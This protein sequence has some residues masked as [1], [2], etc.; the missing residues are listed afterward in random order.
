MLRRTIVTAAAGAVGTMAAAADTARAAPASPGVHKL[1][2][3]SAWPAEAAG[4]AHAVLRFAQ[5][6]RALS[7]GGI[8]IEVL[9]ADRSGVPA[10]GLMDAVAQGEVDL[11]HS[12]AYYWTQRSPGFSFFATVPMGMMANEHYGWLR[13][14]GGLA[15][16]QKLAAEHG[17]M[18]L[19]CGNTG[20]QMGGWFR[21]PLQ[22]VASLK[23]LKLRFPGLGGEVLRR[24]G[25]EPV[26]LPAKDLK[27]ALADGRLDGA[28]W[29]TPWPDVALGLHELCRY[30]YYPGV[31][32]PSHTLE[33]LINP[34]VWQRLGEAQREVLQAAAWLEC[35][36]M[37]AHFHHENA[38]HLD[39]LQ[40]LRQV[41][42]L[43]LPNELMR[44]FRKLAP[45]VVRDAVAKDAFARRIHDSYTAYLA[46]QLR[47]AEMADRAYWQARY[48]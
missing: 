18:V 9:P 40:Q 44:A 45:E 43:R 48:V 23:G 31:H 41:Q 46:Q 1:R 27:A 11:A 33:L 20:V 37:Q 30:Y 21:Q 13:F 38:G 12:T 35:I 22:G 28:E 32:E 3:A 34:K 6:V 42:V 17:V 25:A 24:L 5:R 29:I 39:R 10:L 2:L 19:P 47:W 16:W 14:G 4:A 36:E 15:L 7:A 8:Q 26:L